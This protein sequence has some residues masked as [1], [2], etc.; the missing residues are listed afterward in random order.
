MKALA[1]LKT[2]NR[3]MREDRHYIVVIQLDDESYN[4]FGFSADIEVVKSESLVEGQ[5]EEDFFTWEDFIAQYSNN[6]REND[7]LLI[8]TDSLFVGVL[9]NGVRYRPEGDL[10]QESYES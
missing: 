2:L 9:N 4:C 6:V 7:A 5:K 1:P 10:E 3:Y 8:E